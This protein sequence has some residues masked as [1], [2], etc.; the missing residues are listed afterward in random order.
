MYGV[1]VCCCRVCPDSLPVTFLAG[2]HPSN[3]RFPEQGRL[4]LWLAI[5]DS[6]N[7]PNPVGV[8]LPEG[9]LVSRE[10]SRC[11]A[12]LKPAM[13]EPLLFDLCCAASRRKSPQTHS[14]ENLCRAPKTVHPLAAAV[15]A[16]SSSP[17]LQVPTGILTVSVQN[18][19][20]I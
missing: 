20:P 4:C 6:G 15:H 9:P 8:K 3:L 19:H 18:A 1:C 5:V 10:C 7:W 11:L 14:A 12:W 16:H 13:T 2:P 17:H